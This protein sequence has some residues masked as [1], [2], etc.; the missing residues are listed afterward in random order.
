MTKHFSRTIVRIVV[1][2]VVFSGLWIILSDHALANLLADP[3]ARIQ[4]SIYKGWAFILVTALL[5]SFLLWRE[6][7]ARE[8]MDASLRAS[9]EKSRQEHALLLAV[10]EGI[11]DAVYVKDLKGSYLFCNSSA[12][13]I[14]GKNL[15]EILGKDDSAL[16]STEEAGKIVEAD[17]RVFATGTPLTYEEQIPVQGE[18]R[19]YRSFKGPIRNGQGDVVALFGLSHDITNR[20]RHEAALLESRVKLESALASMTDAV[21]I[22]DAKGNF[23]EFNDAFATY[24]R[25]TSKEQCATSFIEYAD[26]LDVF[27]PD[28]TPVPVE[29]WPVPRALRGETATNAEYILRRKDTGKTWIGSYNFAPIHD[30]KGAIVGSVVTA[31]DITEQVQMEEQLRQA[32]KMEAI[33]R[34]AG[35]VAHDFNNI[36]QAIKGF[37]ELAAWDLS[38]DSAAFG[39]LAEISRAVERAQALVRQLLIFSRREK[40]QNKPFVLGELVSG[41]TKMLSR[42]IGENV[43]LDTMAED[44]DL[45]IW[46]DAGQ[47]EQILMNLCVNAKDAMPEGGTIRISTRSE[48]MDEEFVRQNPWAKKGE[49]VRLKVEDSGCGMAPETLEHIFEPFFTT[50]EIGRG[51]GLGLATVYGIV[52]QHEG[53][54]HVDSRV[55]RGSSFS[56]YFPLADGIIDKK[57]ELEEA[58]P[59][60]GGMETLLVAEDDEMVRSLAMRILKEGGYTVL[61]AQNGEEAVQLFKENRDKIKMVLLDVV[62]PRLSGKM[63]EEKIK[64]ISPTVPILFCTGY[65]SNLLDAGLAPAETTELIFKPYSRDALLR[66]VREMLDAASK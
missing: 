49:Y 12:C 48:T 17:Q 11:S 2:Y 37:N 43:Q 57:D 19:T 54:I 4:W 44:E 1:P 45:T 8:K 60:R 38:A 39:D 47:I 24:H 36:L 41:T 18:L 51:T 20:K 21:F 5:L 34:L 10:T 3:N 7:K 55:G 16:F 63:A 28:G 52:K 31:R 9:E 35:G 42:L 29:Q 50:K 33:G 13:K 14:T 62:M 46:A 23:I 53:F 32:Q 26:I 59:V 61:A 64:E 6:F 30:E 22:S 66:K 65:D 58:A 27:S 25:F 15:A 56:L 40:P